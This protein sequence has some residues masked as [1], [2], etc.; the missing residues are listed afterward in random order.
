MISI[1]TKIYSKIRY[2]FI[3]PHR[4]EG[5]TS[6]SQINIADIYQ[7]SLPES[8]VNCGQNKFEISCY[9][10]VMVPPF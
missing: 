10:G 4:Y 9:F 5:D 6:N 2:N 7:F 1:P 8:G 3:I